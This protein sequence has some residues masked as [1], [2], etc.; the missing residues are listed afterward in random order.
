[1]HIHHDI[2]RN[3]EKQGV[4]DDRITSNATQEVH[5]EAENFMREFEG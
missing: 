4:E 2:M 3:S 5:D 1:V